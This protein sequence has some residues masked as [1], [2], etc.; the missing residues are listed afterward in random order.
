MRSDGWVVAFADFDFVVVLVAVD[1]AVEPVAL[2]AVDFAVVPV[3]LVDVGF[4]V[5]V[6]ALVVLAAG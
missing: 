1:F 2:A 6:V 3:I 4:F 5:V